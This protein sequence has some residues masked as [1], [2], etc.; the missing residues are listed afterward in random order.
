MWDQLAQ[1]C[2]LVQEEGTGSNNTALDKEL[3]LPQVQGLLL[4]EPTKYDI[5]IAFSFKNGKN[6]AKYFFY[7]TTALIVEGLCNPEL[8]EEEGTQ[9]CFLIPPFLILSK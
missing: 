2:K 6:L 8:E 5:C 7:R 9:P 3:D 1:K 4:G